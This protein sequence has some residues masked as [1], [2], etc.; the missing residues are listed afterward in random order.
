MNDN[1]LPGYATLP[2]HD[3][4]KLLQAKAALTKQRVQALYGPLNPGADGPQPYEGAAARAAH[5][6]AITAQCDEVIAATE[7]NLEAIANRESTERD[8]SNRVRHSHNKLRIITEN[9]WMV[10]NT[11]FTGMFFDTVNL[12]PDEQAL[13]QRR[14]KQ[15]ISVF[16]YGKD[17]KPKRFSFTDADFYGNGAPLG[18]KVL[19]S[20]RVEYPL[21][22]INKG[23]V[24]ES[25]L[26]TFD[27]AN[28]MAAAVDA[29]AFAIA[30]AGAYTTWTFTGAKIDRVVNTHSR[31]KTA[32]FPLTNIIAA[33][34]NPNLLTILRNIKKYCG[35][36]GMGAFPDGDLAPT[37]RI[38]VP[39]GQI[40]AILG[41]S[42][43][44]TTVSAAK[45]SLGEQLQKEGW[46]SFHYLG[47]DWTL[48]PDNTLAPNTLYPQLNKP[49]GTIFFKPSLDK[50][51]VKVEE[52]A[53]ELGG[54]LESR[55]LK[56]PLWAVIPVS[57]VVNAMKVTFT[58]S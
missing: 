48:I 10:G 47:T 1:V 22:D 52:D 45:S 36:W 4:L 29:E 7:A 30:A 55:Y 37:G 23:S 20:A 11:L 44:T 13:Y 34:A 2:R 43:I 49:I 25:A 50:E 51:V 58:I 38:L 12:A 33:G 24:R 9:N 18:F 35:Q 42:D 56:K 28:D 46:T 21:I 5:C 8:H 14:T 41:I 39:S 3:R 53:G 27:L 26:E 17:G 19:S 6:G 57:R 40:D 32:N 15:E 54:D 31:V 16:Q